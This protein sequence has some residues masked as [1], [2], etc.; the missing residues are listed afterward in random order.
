MTIDALCEHFANDSIPMEEFE[1]RVEV[2]HRAASVEELKELL[3][4]LPGANV[5]APVG[6]AAPAPRPR[7]R[8][9]AAAHEREQG[10]VVAIM[11]GATRKGR[12][13]P[14]RTTFGFALMGGME[15]DFREAF[16]P[17]GVTE[18]QIVAIMGG[19]GIIVPPGVN[20][21]SHGVGIMGGFEHV[22]GEYDYDPD[23]PT[24]RISGVAL[25]GG[26]DIRVRHP[27]ESAR[28]ARRRQKQERKERRRLKDSWE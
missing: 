28:D 25:M 14:A 13:H 5:P 10:F 11:G 27:G 26:V 20:V 18:V 12:W 22:A 21:E 24:L 7:A 19:A 23:A 9:T 4:D 17:P 3:R 6:H 8:V 1:R 16:L 2:A 15:L